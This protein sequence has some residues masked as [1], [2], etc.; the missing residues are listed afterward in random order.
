MQEKKRVERVVKVGGSLLDLPDLAKRLQPWRP[1]LF[2]VG[3]GA[4]ADAVRSLHRIHRLPEE[5]S[6]WLALR[7]CTLHAHF[8]AHLLGLPVVSRPE[9]GPGVLDAVAFCEA[10]EANP[11]HLPH[12][13]EATSDSLAAR[14]AE[15][16]RAELILLKSTDGPFEALV[17]SV[18]PQIVHRTGLRVQIVNLRA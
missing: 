2:V 12:S 9:Q 14:V 16:A 17:D 11:E 15:V 13:W 7:T 4:M 10:D 6:H 5:V 8:L 18:C 3:G 1:A